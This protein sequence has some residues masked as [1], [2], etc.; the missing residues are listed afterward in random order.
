MVK[1]ENLQLNILEVLAKNVSFELILDGNKTKHKAKILENQ[2]IFG[3]EF[4]EDVSLLLSYYPKET[5]SFI[6][7]LRKVYFSINERQAA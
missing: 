1:T 3:V 6:R 4:P 7:K 2:D 5:K